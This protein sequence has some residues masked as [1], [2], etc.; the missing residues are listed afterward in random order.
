MS[1]RVV[2]G[3]LDEIAPGAAKRYEVGRHRLAVVRCDDDDLY[4]IGDTC[5]HADFSL[6][7]G[8]VYCEEREIECWKHGST[9]SLVDGEPQSLPATRAVPV[10]RVEVIDGDI[11]V[12]VG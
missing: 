4:A 12:E 10:Y 3:R 11:V 9:F 1:E 5:S 2:L 8:E 7:E 6:S